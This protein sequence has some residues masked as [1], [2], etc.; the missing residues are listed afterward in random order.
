MAG[1]VHVYIQY[2]VSRTCIGYLYNI[3]NTSVITQHHVIMC[4][5]VYLYGMKQARQIFSM[6]HFLIR[7]PG[8][9]RYIVLTQ[10]FVHI[11]VQKI[12]IHY[13]HVRAHTKNVYT[14]CTC[15]CVLTNEPVLY[16]CI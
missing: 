4:I 15:T 10:Y 12:Y 2:I 13:V 11:H 5:S 1:C 14:L 3:Y 8:P 9:P 16:T 6:E 7:C